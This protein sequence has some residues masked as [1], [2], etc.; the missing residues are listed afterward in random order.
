MDAEVDIELN[1]MPF[2]ILPILH[3]FAHPKWRP[4]PRWR[5]TLQS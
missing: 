4:L 2:L 3:R 1:K 5:M